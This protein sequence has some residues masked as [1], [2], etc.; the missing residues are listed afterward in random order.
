MIYFIQAG[1]DGPIRI[2]YAANV[3]HRIRMLQRRSPIPL[4]LMTVIGGSIEVE[5]Y[6]HNRFWHLRQ[7][8]KWFKADQEI[9]VFIETPVLPPDLLADEPH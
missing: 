5:A 3:E 7:H 4:R 9:L 6:L 1:N 8:G 2:G